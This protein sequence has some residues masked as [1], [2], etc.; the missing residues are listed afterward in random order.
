AIVGVGALFPLDGRVDL[1]FHAG[2]A[3]GGVDARFPLESGRLAFTV[4]AAI[5]GD[6]AGWQFA[7]LRA[8]GR[9]E[10]VGRWGGGYHAAGT[11]LV[12]RLRR[13]RRAPRRRRPLARRRRRRR[14]PHR[15]A[16]VTAHVIAV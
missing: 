7:Y 2:L 14:A 3:R 1:S 9:F 13:R 6:A 15:L 16:V 10:L 8:T 12:A 11:P 5:R 4:G